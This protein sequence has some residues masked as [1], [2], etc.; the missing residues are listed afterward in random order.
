[1]KTEEIC[2]YTRRNELEPGQ[3]FRCQGGIVKL[4]SR[5]AGDG[6][7]WN[8]LDWHDGWCSY[9]S[10]IEPGDLEGDPLQ[11]DR[12]VISAALALKPACPAELAVPFAPE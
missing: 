8:V 5:V 1:M 9:D 3:V 6:T 2:W 12:A 7:K 11:D 4:D 10:E